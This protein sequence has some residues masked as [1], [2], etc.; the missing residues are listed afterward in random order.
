MANVATSG[1]EAWKAISIWRGVLQRNAV[2]HRHKDRF[3]DWAGQIFFP[4]SRHRAGSPATASNTTTM[5]DA[6]GNNAPRDGAEI[7]TVPVVLTTS[8]PGAAI[9]ETPYMVPAAWRR[10]HLS[11]LVNRVLKT[12]GGEG[13]VPF[14]F[15]VN[16][17]ILRMS[18][19]AYL[20]KH[21]LD[22]EAT[23]RLEYVR[24]TLPPRFE[25]IIPQDDWVSSLS[26]RLPAYPSL[27]E[28]LPEGSAPLFLTGS[29]DGTARV[30]AADSPDAPRYSLRAAPAGAGNAAL[31]SAA[32]VPPLAGSSASAPESGPR[33]VTT[34]LDGSV[35]M[36][37]FA[38]SVL[39]P[40]RIAGPERQARLLWSGAVANSPLASARGG[41]K[42]PILPLSALAVSADGQTLATGGWDGLVSLW[43]AS[44]DAEEQEDPQEVNE[45]D[46][47][48]HRVPDVERDAELLPAQL[49]AAADEKEQVPDRRKRRKGRAGE[50][51]PL[52][53]A[54][55]PT[56]VLRHVPPVAVAA[57]APAAGGV[58][59][60][61]GLSPGTNAR[62]TGVLFDALH[63]N[64]LYSAG[65]NGTVKVWDTDQAGSL[66][67][68]KASDKT[69]LSLS[70]LAYGGGGAQGG[71]LA[72]G[73]LERSWGLW[74]LRQGTA[75]GT[76]VVAGV[77][78]AHAGPVTAVAGHPRSSALLATASLDGT[79]K[80]WDVRSLGQ[81][82]FTLRPPEL[83]QAAREAE[84]AEAG[85]L[86]RLANLPSERLLAVDWSQDGQT[87]VAAG[88]DCRI[89]VWH[90][91]NIGLTDL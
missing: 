25:S 63:Q 47:D 74:D 56:L 39:G 24:S 52:H 90:G 33:V 37:G 12:Q 66:L 67:D 55:A 43:N 64:R 79:A 58:G 34:G 48:D 38:S 40:E 3:Y 26:A 15:L 53:G 46:V 16:G 4:R 22:T 91:T 83:D 23:L 45:L 80:I 13:N 57:P 76:N 44:G 18:L 65:W 41:Y 29:F 85:T 87:I 59:S 84:A 68:S 21:G 51:A 8:I 70:Q 54:A 50:P 11:A 19:G 31:A 35:R 62:V 71:L 17:E 5:V 73:H 88:E 82:L 28:F 72:T 89:S 69:I 9:P 81:P 30:Y 61:P 75:A 60:Q 1:E 7:R 2:P 14:D 86:P 32:W 36:F 6:N 10:T 78:E 20:E 42:L 77:N 49:A 27:S